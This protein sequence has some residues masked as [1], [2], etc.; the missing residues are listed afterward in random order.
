[1]SLCRFKTDLFN[2]FWLL[3]LDLDWLGDSLVDLELLEFVYGI[4]FDEVCGL[5]G[6]M[7]RT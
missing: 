2:V 7:A 6:D 4:L 3:I 1:M 5:L